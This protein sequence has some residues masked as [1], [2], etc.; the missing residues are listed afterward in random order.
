MG[1]NAQKKRLARHNHQ[2]FPPSQPKAAPP[3]I[4]PQFAGIRQA[5]TGTDI[6]AHIRGKTAIGFLQETFDCCSEKCIVEYVPAFQ[7]DGYACL[8]IPRPSYTDILKYLCQYVVLFRTGNKD[9]TTAQVKDILGYISHLKSLGIRIVYYADDLIFWAN[10]NAPMAFIQASDAIIV[11][12]DVLKEVLLSKGNVRKPIVV[13]PTHI[14]LS[15]FDALPAKS[16]VPLSNRF[17]VLITSQGRIGINH[18]YEICEIAD[19]DPELAKDIEWIFNCAGVAEVRSVINRFRNLK[20]TYID[21]LSLENYYSLIKSVNLILH[22]AHPEDL[23]YLCPP[24]MRQLWLD[25]KSEVKYTMAGAAR[26]PI[27]SSPSASYKQAITDGVTG[28]VVTTPQEFVEKIRLLKNDRNLCKTMGLAARA[29]IEKRYDIRVRYPQYRDAIIGK[30]EVETDPKIFAVPKEQA[31]SQFSLFIPPIEGG[32]RTFYENMKRWLPVVSDEKWRVVDNIGSSDAAIAIAFVAADE[33]IATK[34]QNPNFKIIYRLDGLPMNFEGELDPTN[35]ATMQKLFKYADTLI[36]QSKHCFKI[37]RDRNLIPPDINS[38]G[39]I[40]HN[41]VDLDI[42]STAG[43]SYKLPNASR[44]NLLNFNWSTFPHKRLDLLK[45]LV[46]SHISNPEIRFYMMGNYYS[47]S[48]I[49]NVNFWKE[50]PNV[51]YLGKMQNQSFEA[52]RVLAS[53][54][55]ASTAVIFTSEMEGSPNTV[56]EALGC[57][58]PV[59]YN[60]AADIVPEILGKS[61]IPLESL[62][63]IFDLDVQNRI[64]EE[65]KP[66]SEEYSMEKCVRKYLEVLNGCTPSS[67]V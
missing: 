42:F 14:A 54:Y 51:T 56:L 30:I 3:T 46:T 26:I 24:D 35:L 28:Y 8:L 17:K 64:K 1:R 38:E 59:I 23:A 19:T 15:S 34:I 20:K 33:L 9:V 21:W 62:N 45:Q 53:I 27:I 29:D 47:T 4:P 52:K 36:W 2:V 10:N 37:W 65:M 58:C 22:P 16:V 12:N 40:I 25:S 48:Q 11:S 13:V 67:P 5:S 55:R 7:Q 32:P 44:Y 60:S 41:G 6:V 43:A 39:P 57:G 31:T 61:C 49:A 66:I 18:S 50:Y 63:T